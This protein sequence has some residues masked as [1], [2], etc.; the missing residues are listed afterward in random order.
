MAMP[1]IS[2]LF[3]K[4]NGAGRL[5]VKALAVVAVCALSLVG[6]GAVGCAATDPPLP[7]SPLPLA[8]HTTVATAGDVATLAVRV[9]AIPPNLPKYDR[10]DWR[11]WVDDDG[12]CQDARQETLIAEAVGAVRYERA[13]AGRR[14]DEQRR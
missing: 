6:L 5:R 8:A 7:L 2:A 9:A 13:D 1:I 3:G 4:A 10:G 14:G 12:D 11:H